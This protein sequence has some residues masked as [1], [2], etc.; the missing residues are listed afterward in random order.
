MP[1]GGWSIA[2]LSFDGQNI[3]ASKGSGKVAK[4]QASNGAVLG[5]YSTGPWP[6]KIIFDGA[7][8]WVSDI[9]DG[10]LVKLRA[11]D[12]VNLG[13]FPMNPANAMTFDGRNIWMGAYDSGYFLY[14]IRADDG[15]VLD[16][17]SLNK[18]VACLTY[19]GTNII[20]G[21]TDGRIC[22]VHASEGGILGH[23]NTG[24]NYSSRDIIFDG[25]NIWILYD[26]VFPDQ[27]N[28]VKIRCAD[29][30]VLGTFKTPPNP[31]NLAFDGVKIW[32]LSHDGRV[33]VY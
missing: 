23:I 19:D 5:E 21:L 24:I 20:V 13:T 15:N 28:L 7:N 8:I 6:W 4:V 16:T 18:D 3:W 27:N 26:L 31:Q 22:L 25:E 9:Q 1:L 11:I 10:T 33:A 32:V 17:I 12:G 2:G 29:S 14:K 30:V